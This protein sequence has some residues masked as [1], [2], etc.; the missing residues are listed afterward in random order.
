MTSFA[1]KCV[2]VTGGSRGIGEA[3][4]RW[5]A[6]EG[7]SVV[8]SGTSARAAEVASAIVGAGGNAIGVRGD[9]TDPAHVAEI[10]D[11]AVKAFGGVDVSVQNAG[12]ITIA[13]L[14]DLTMSDWERV[15]AVNTTAAFACCKRAI[16]DMRAHGRGGRL[17]NIASAQSRQGGVYTP[18]Y[19]ASKFAL[20]GFTQ[21]LAREVA[22]ERITVNAVCPG[23][24][25]TEMWTYNDKAF[26]ALLGAYA[27]GE[28]MAAWVH[29]KVPMD[30]VGTSGDIAGVV[31]F[32]AG[33]AAAYITGQ[34]INVDGGLIMS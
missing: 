17:I 21:S 14:E 13:K 8:V 15:I 1:G 6:H 3:I 27:P 26:G 22:K 31:G 32:L 33:Q 25:D 2:V 34:T 10:Y 23:I 24:I 11:T 30:R 28:L 7:A 29:E 12:V 9:V 20:V 16:L 19:A 4:A 5:F 18:H